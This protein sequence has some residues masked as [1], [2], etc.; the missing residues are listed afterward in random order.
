[1]NLKHAEFKIQSSSMLNSVKIRTVAI[2]SNRGNYIIRRLIRIWGIVFCIETVEF[3]IGLK[4]I[5]NTR[6]NRDE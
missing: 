2:S 5:L 3:V 4:I 6:G 1:M